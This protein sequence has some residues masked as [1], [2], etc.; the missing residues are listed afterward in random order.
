MLQQ[1]GV[2]ETIT[3]VIGR[4]G[5]GL[6]ALVLAGAAL[7]AE[8]VPDERTRLAEAYF[9]ASGYE[10][11]YSDPDK[12]MAMVEGQ[13]QAMFTGM[14][15]EMT[16]EH[17]ADFHRGMAG[18]MPE[19]KRVAVKTINGMKPDLV[20][21]LARTYSVEELRALV[22]FFGSP[23]GRDVVAKNPQLM[24]ALMEINGVHLTGMMKELQTILGSQ[25]SAARKPAENSAK[26][27]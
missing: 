1:K 25:A 17:A 26:G 18:F 23:V 15:A 10:E 16:P 27:K 14:T 11:M 3:G 2:T 21:A 9:R 22:Q 20:A 12:L 13:M 4:L 5:G 7:A 8:P 19:L 6:L 24:Q